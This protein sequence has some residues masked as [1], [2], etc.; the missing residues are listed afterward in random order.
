MFKIKDHRD[1]IG[2]EKVNLEAKLVPGKSA[3]RK[4]GY[5]PDVSGKFVLF[6]FLIVP[7]VW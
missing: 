7:N 3:W 1:K 2:Q 6:H 5:R 4:P